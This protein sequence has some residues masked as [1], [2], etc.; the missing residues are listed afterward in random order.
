MQPSAHATLRIA[1]L[2]LAVNVALAS[3]KLIA[4]IVGHSGALVADAIE[5]LGD[6]A[7]SIVI[8]SGL[9][10]A[11]R[12]ADPNHPYGH[13]KA[14]SLAGLAVALL[15]FV[16][17]VAIT[18]EAVHDIRTPHPAPAPFTLA[19]LLA[20]VAIKTAMFVAARRTAR[21]HAS[22]AVEIDAGHHVSDAITSLAAFVGISVALFGQRLFPAAAL[23]WPAADD[24]AAI[25]AAVVIAYNATKLARLPLAELM[26]AAGSED[27]ARVSAA[28]RD[29]AAAVPGV[30]AIE[31][32]HARKAGSR[33]HLDMHVQVD[34]DL[35]IREAH[36]IGGRVRATI[37]QNLPAVTDVLIHLEPH[38]SPQ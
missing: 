35:P 11:A 13:G 24:Y 17:A 23:N 25:L 16:A 36:A 37:R 15:M 8:Y 12:P 5:S 6:I 33:F 20:V 4:G 3:A 29:L 26:D 38:T 21:R 2:G 19:V 22:S 30:R 9:R 1:L 7:G 18:V 31:K 10:I 27:Q 34:P 14:E 28:A 32:L